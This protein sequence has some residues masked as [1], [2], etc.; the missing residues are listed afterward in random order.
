MVENINILSLSDLHIDQNK[1]TN[2]KIVLSA[3]YDDLRVIN[4][5]E[6]KPNYI[7]FNGDLVQNPDEQDS[8]MLFLEQFFLPLMETL[9][10]PASNILFVPGNHDVS[11]ATIE[12]YKTENDGIISR[13]DDQEAINRI[14]AHQRASAFITERQNAFFQTLGALQIERN[15]LQNPFIIQTTFDADR[16]AIVGLNTAIFS[17]AGTAG[18]ERL[19]I[20]FPDVALNDAFA[21]IPSGYTVITVLH[22]PLDWFT[23]N[24]RKEIRASLLQRSHLT[25]FGHLHEPEPRLETTPSG[26]LIG[27]QLSSLFSTRN[28]SN[29]YAIVSISRDD[30][31]IRTTYRTYFDGRRKFDKG[32]NVAADG[33]FYPTIEA[34]KFFLKNEETLGHRKFRQWV[35]DFVRPQLAPTLDECTAGK[36][37]SSI[38]VEPPLI[39]TVALESVGR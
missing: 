10:V 27:V 11:R 14:Y 34:E 7:I 5:T 4:E 22:H 6:L 30:Q 1:I 16:L 25:I 28:Y 31:H 32:L 36:P 18:P 9:S 17:M 35:S 26:S 8:Y 12:R 19:R 15:F 33:V 38:F 29:G 13:L 23:E 20:A 3:L 21:S 37:L 2:Q 24:S 39:Q